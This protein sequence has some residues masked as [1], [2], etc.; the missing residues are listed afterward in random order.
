[1]QPHPVEIPMARAHLHFAHARFPQA[2]GAFRAAVGVDPTAVR[3]HLGLAD[4]LAALGR[5]GEAVDQLVEAAETFGARDEHEHAISLLGR[6]LAIDPSRMELDVDLAMVEEAMG[7]HDA[8]VTRVE[9]LADRYMDVGR[10]EEAAELLRFLM[11][12]GDDVE[13]P[14]AVEELL[15]DVVHAEPVNTALITGDTVIAR[16]PLLHTLE[17]MPVA[18]VPEPEV[19]VAAEP[20]P[21]LDMVTRVARVQPH[22]PM[23]DR[24]RARA[25]LGHAA[26]RPRRAASRPTEPIAIR[27]GLTMR[28]AQE[29]DVTMRFRRPR[30]LD[31]AI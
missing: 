3:A 28:P 31:V 11:S 26:G 17:M 20:E 5:R 7:R 8:A 29:E 10:T 12:W 9:G 19:V 30:Q 15:A 22:N 23:V 4:A 1:M 16:N 13:E 6:A 14:E 25:G 21:E 2:V 27:R 24:L 18:T